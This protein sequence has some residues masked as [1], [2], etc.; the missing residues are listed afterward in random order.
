MRDE[1]F[2]VGDRPLVEVRI[3]RG[4]VRVESG[5]DGRVQVTARGPV[6]RLTIDQA[7]GVVTVAEEP[8]MLARGSF[9]ITVRTPRDAAV[10]AQLASADL[11]VDTEIR[12]LRGRTASGDVRA[13]EVTDRIDLRTASGDVDVD[14]AGAV[15]I[16]SASGEVRVGVAARPVNVGTA[17][18]DIRLGTADDEVG[19]KTASGDVTVGTFHG[20]SLEARTV[21]GDV[22][23]ALPAGRRVSYD[24]K[25]LSG[26][27][28]LP[29]GEA[30]GRG[31]HDRDR[32]RRGDAT[33]AATA[34]S[35]PGGIAGTQEAPAAPQRVRLRVKSVSGDV[36][37]R[38]A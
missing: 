27:V 25:T 9:D 33:A 38:T 10:D 21:S 32:D 22:T 26:R 37:V 30:R 6:D 36:T 14:R 28:S 35:A 3:A 1:T 34:G 16:T 31:R 13:R 18:G 23:L 11:A 20:P 15:D 8:G 2:T 4:R 17:S 24:I 5:D 7:G 29:G 12:E 19:A